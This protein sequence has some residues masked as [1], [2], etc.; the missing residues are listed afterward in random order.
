[1]QWKNWKVCLPKSIALGLCLAP[2]FAQPSFGK[3]WRHEGFGFVARYELGASLAFPHENWPAE[4]GNFLSENVL[5]KNGQLNH[6]PN[7]FLE[8]ITPRFFGH[9]GIRKTHRLHS[10]DRFCGNVAEAGDDP[11]RTRLGS[12]IPK[13]HEL[14]RNKDFASRRVAGIVTRQ[15]EGKTLLFFAYTQGGISY[16]QIGTGLA[17]ANS[18]RLINLPF[19]SIG[20]SAGVQE[21]PLRRLVGF[22]NKVQTPT[23]ERHNRQG[24]YCHDHLSNQVTPCLQEYDNARRD[25]IL[26]AIS[27]IWIFFVFGIGCRLGLTGWQLTG[28]ANDCYIFGGYLLAVLGGML[29]LLFF[30]YLL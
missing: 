19:R 2:M 5:C 25:L 17:L 6:N 9:F 26:F 12:N 29:T 24:P 10:L 18:S 7:H 20:G 11:N 28:H 22:P 23:G 27:I 30:F 1:M 3:D 8:V 14:Y 21:R 4:R 13:G 16:S 15:R